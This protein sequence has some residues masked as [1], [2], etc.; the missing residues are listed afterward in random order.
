M[1]WGGTDGDREKRAESL[2]H[3]T[4]GPRVGGPGGGPRG[5]QRRRDGEAGEAQGGAGRGEEGEIL[6]PL[7]TASWGRGAGGGKECER[8]VVRPP[9]SALPSALARSSGPAPSACIIA[10]PQTRPPPK[11]PPTSCSASRPRPKSC[12]SSR[13]RPAPHQSRCRCWETH[14]RG[15]RGGEASGALGAL[16]GP[17]PPRGGPGRSVRWLASPVKA[18]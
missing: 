6:R 8:G 2:K 3:R 9:A 17:C 5:L 16:T 1:R 14:L 15:W 18:D 10:P 13:P 11:A 7:E 4:C 12:P